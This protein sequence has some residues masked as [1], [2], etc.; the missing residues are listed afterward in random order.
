[1][2]SLWFHY[3]YPAVQK[4][5]PL[6]LVQGLAAWIALPWVK[7][8]LKSEVKNPGTILRF[9]SRVRVSLKPAKGNQ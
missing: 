5:V 9:L 7:R 1:M 4:G 6:T 3:L 2:H 8:Y